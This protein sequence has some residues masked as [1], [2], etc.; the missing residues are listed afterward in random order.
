LNASVAIAGAA[1]A[2]GRSLSGVARASGWRVG[3]LGHGPGSWTGPHAPDAWRAGEIDSV[4]LDA[5]ADDLG[6]IDLLVNASGSAA[7]GASWA[8]PAADFERT[9]ATTVRIL[10]WIRLHSPRTRLICLSSAAVYGSGH[11]GTI[12]EGAALAPI[13]PYGHHKLLM[14]R[15]VIFWARTFGIEA[16]II[17]LFSI[18]GPGLHKQLVYELGRKLMARPDRLVLSGTGA[19]TRDWMWI[20][21][22]ARLTLHLAD[23]ASIEAPVFNG[24]TGQ[25]HTVSEMA[26][27]LLAA[28][29]AQTTLSFNG[30]VRPG[31]PFHLV[32]CPAKAQATGFRPR[33]ALRDGLRDLASAMVE[34]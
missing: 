10:D 13:S 24:G 14:E 6:G 29:D 4:A 7:V 23:H 22:A 17:R 18:Y 28:H 9:V 16:V 3:G 19:E 5:L 8:D 20:G 15:A 31:D 1:G 2:I 21:D 33:V 11:A 32:G 12:E 34:A 27:M 25:A 30:E 26:H